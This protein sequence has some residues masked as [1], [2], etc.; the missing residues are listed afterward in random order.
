MKTLKSQVFYAT[1]LVLISSF[2]TEVMG[3]GPVYKWYEQS[4]VSYFIYWC[5]LIFV[6]RLVN[7]NVERKEAAVTSITCPFCGTGIVRDGAWGHCPGCGG[8]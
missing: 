2:L 3:V 6:F 5:G 4:L 8:N 1:I 7:L